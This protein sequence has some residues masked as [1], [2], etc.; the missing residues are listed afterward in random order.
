MH[1][2]VVRLFSTTLLALS[3]AA[4]ASAGRAPAER[5][6]DRLALYQAH[7]GAP[8]ERFQFWDMKRFEVL[9]E[10]TLAVWTTIDDAWLIT[11]MRPCVG[12]EFA[13]GIGISSTQRHVNQ[14]FDTVNFDNQRC[15]IA[16]IRPVDGAALERA[17]D[18]RR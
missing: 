1:A 13:H 18:G 16:E 6:S 15:R 12:L 3:L 5:M 10:T 2:T 8:V 11:V 7:A 9:G 14:R 4:C 17:E